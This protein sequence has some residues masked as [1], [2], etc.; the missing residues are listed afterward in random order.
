MK[1]KQILKETERPPNRSPPLITQTYR[2][3]S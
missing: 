1:E 3:P 2:R